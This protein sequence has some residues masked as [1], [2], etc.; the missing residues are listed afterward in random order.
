MDQPVAGL[1]LIDKDEFAPSEL[2]SVGSRFYAVRSKM[3][4]GVREDSCVRCSLSSRHM[5]QIKASLARKDQFFGE[6]DE[7]YI[8][9]MQSVVTILDISS[10]EVGYRWEGANKCWP[11]HFARQL[12]D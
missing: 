11:F 2:I 9:K 6:L 5:P 3:S 1:V 12:L 4:F 7:L 8:F 10:S